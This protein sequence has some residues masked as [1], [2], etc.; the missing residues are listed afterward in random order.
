MNIN[1]GFDKLSTALGSILGIIL[2]S[3][4]VKLYFFSYEK[5]VYYG[6]MTI[7]EEALSLMMIFLF[8]FLLTLGTV[9]VIKN[10]ILWVVRGFNVND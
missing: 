9:K 1:K 10:V 4:F 8:W 5:S 7:E 2:G 3:Y 6:H